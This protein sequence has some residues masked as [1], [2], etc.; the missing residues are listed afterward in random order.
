MY[1]QPHLHVRWGQPRVGSRPCRAAAWVAVTHGRRVAMERAPKRGF[2][3]MRVFRKWAFAKPCLATR[4]GATNSCGFVPPRLPLSRAVVRSRPSPTTLDPLSR[5][6]HP[7]PEFFR[8]L[9][10]PSAVSRTLRTEAAVSAPPHAL[11]DRVA[12]GSGAQLRRNQHP[13]ILPQPIHHRAFAFASSVL[14]T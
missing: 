10:S 5:N 8:S 13:T 6:M 12:G 11:H 4:Q 14:C 2:S 7:S 1:A 9:P 3:K